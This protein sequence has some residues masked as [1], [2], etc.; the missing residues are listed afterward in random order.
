MSEVDELEAIRSKKLEEMMERFSKGREPT[1]GEVI[2]SPVAITDTSFDETI[3]KHPLVVIDCWA[4]WC[5]PCQMIAPVVDAMAKD[6]AGRIV[7]GKLN[8]DENPVISRQYRI[9]SI[10]V[11]L[12]FKE[13]VLVD[14]IIGAMPRAALEPRIRKYL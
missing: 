14:Q 4:V 6:Y 7:F 10:P 13:G 3:R 11:L 8:V 2:S 12:I 9:M 5:R 1:G